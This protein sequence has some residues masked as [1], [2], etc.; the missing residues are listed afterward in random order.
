MGGK[1]VAFYCRG[2]FHAG[3][4]IRCRLGVIL[5]VAVTCSSSSSMSADWG[6]SRARRGFVYVYVCL[7]VCCECVRL[8]PTPCTLWNCTKTKCKAIKFKMA[9]EV[10]PVEGHHTL[11]HTTVNICCIGLYLYARYRNMAHTLPRRCA[12]P[13]RPLLTR[14]AGRRGT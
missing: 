4:V 11:C 7:C 5:A 1:V 13:E 14:E 9:V 8:S 10:V 3:E 6:G 2:T 12:P